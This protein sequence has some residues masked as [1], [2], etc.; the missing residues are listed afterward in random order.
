MTGIVGI[1]ILVFEI[2]MFVDA[3][4]RQEW[5]WAVFIGMSVGTSLVHG[6]FGFGLAS[7]LYFLFVYRPQMEW[8]GGGVR[9]EMPGAA[10]RG[11]IRELQAQIHHL[12]KAHHHS[13]L[14]DI[15]AS[16]G[17]LEKAEA[18]YRAALE[19]DD[20]DLDTQAHFGRLLL[21]QGKPDAAIEWLEKVVGEDPG[22]EYGQTLMALAE[23]FEKL[24]RDQEACQTWE[25]VLEKNDYSRAKVSLAE[26]LVKQGDVDRA[27]G[28]ARDVV[29]DF[30]HVPAF[31]RKKE[32][33]WVRRARNLL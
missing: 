4:R 28:L 22:H 20:E 8:G 26:L 17:K 9:M 11:R 6:A 30:V 32:K 29:Q 7:I 14:G 12:D 31:Q 5:I 16:Q 21:A 19:R 10:T 23:T 33:K 15:Y 18:S 24:G 13:Q 25:R 27:R 2:W 1:L 3:L